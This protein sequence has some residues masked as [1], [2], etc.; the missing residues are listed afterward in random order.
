MMRRPII[1]KEYQSGRMRL[2]NIVKKA[3]ECVGLGAA[4]VKS[5]SYP[6][7]TM[8]LVQMVGSIFALPQHPFAGMKASTSSLH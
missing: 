2:L 4:S 5:R 6:P 1:P 3:G 8:V 7:D